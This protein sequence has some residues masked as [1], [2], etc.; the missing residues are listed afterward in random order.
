MPTVP[1]Q[2]TC[3]ELGCNNP[4]STTVYCLQ[5][6]GR[7]K[8]TWVT[9]YTAPTPERRES[10]AQYDTKHWQKLR[11]VQL[12]KEPLCSCCKSR[13]IVTPAHHVDHVFPWS[14]VGKQA[15]F[16][17]LFQSLCNSCHSRKTLLE[18]TGVYRYYHSGTYK[19]YIINDYNDIAGAV[20]SG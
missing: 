15:F 13:N 3:A 20:L 2:Q 19:D 6:G 1:Q 8:T 5:H 12:S 17:N 11:Q 7:D 4:R 16:I 10:N 14:K 9:K 18:A